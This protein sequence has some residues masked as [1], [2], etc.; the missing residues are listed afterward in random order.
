[1]PVEPLD[2]IT[3][4]ALLSKLLTM[5]PIPILAVDSQLDVVYGNHASQAMFGRPRLGIDTENLLTVL[6][7][8]RDLDHASF[9]TPDGTWL[10]HSA[11]RQRLQ[12]E[13]RNKKGAFQVELEIMP[14]KFEE[15]ELTIVVLHDM[16]SLNGSMATIFKAHQELEEFNRVAIGREIRM[17]A[18][19]QEVN[20]LLQENGLPPRYTD[21][22]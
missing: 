7:G 1:M 19:K 17:V 10:L 22:D 3:S 15:L 6:P 5:C 14:L 18:L 9:G 4:E 2:H 11:S 13:G 12:I 16:T 20:E 21:D 8:L